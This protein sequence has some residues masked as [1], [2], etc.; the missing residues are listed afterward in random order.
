MASPAI[1]EA[2]KAQAAED[3]AESIA[4]LTDHFGDL[5]NSYAVLSETL[6]RLTA[7]CEAFGVNVPENAPP[8][9]QVAKGKKP[10]S[11]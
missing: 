1:I 10:S 5:A 11:E 4:E 6:E 9:A 2:R 7:A 8:K 3:Q